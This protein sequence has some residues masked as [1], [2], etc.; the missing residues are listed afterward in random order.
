M[1]YDSVIYKVRNVVCSYEG[2]F[3]LDSESNQ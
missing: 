2:L 3:P 1:N